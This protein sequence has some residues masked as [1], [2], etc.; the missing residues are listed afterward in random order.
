MICFC[1]FCQKKFSTLGGAH[2]D[3]F[4][5]Q[6]GSKKI[7]FKRFYQLFQNY[8]WI[9]TQININYISYHIPLEISQKK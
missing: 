4:S 9:A 1:Y 8:C 6:I 2:N 3:P 5:V 7:I